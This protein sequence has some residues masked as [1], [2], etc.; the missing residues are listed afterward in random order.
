MDVMTVQSKIADLE[1]KITELLYTFTKETGCT[2]EDVDLR[3]YAIAE[4]NKRMPIPL[5]FVD[6]EVKL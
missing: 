4:M 1:Q 2:I 6:V 3:K 5:Y